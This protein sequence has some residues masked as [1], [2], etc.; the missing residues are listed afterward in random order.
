MDRM[1]PKLPRR[2]AIGVKES[3]G[4][5]ENKNANAPRSTISIEIRMLNLFQIPSPS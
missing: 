4:L 5:F 3:C 1:K 2:I